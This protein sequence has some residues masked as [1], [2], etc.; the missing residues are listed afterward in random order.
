M[1]IPT[2]LPDANVLVPLSVRD[3]IL[4]AAEAG[5][6]QV[7]WTDAILIE[8]ERTLVRQRL[9]TAAQAARLAQCYGIC[10]QVQSSASALGRILIA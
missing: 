4:R 2:I 6:C 8:V 3:T 10:H 7:R 1:P 5:L 9:T